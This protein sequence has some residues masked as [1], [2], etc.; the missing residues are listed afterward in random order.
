MLEYFIGLTAQSCAQL[1]H[2]K[3]NALPFF[4]EA[5]PSHLVLE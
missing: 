2:I 4:E 1:P 3:L 5:I